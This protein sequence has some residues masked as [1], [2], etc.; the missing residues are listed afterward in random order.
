MFDTEFQIVNLI[1]GIDFKTEF[2][3]SALSK[4]LPITDIGV[5]NVSSISYYGRDDIIVRISSKNN[6]RGLIKTSAGKVKE[7]TM[8]NIIDIDYQTEGKNIHFKVSKTNIHITGL[9]SYKMFENATENFIKYLIETE[10]K[11]KK[12]MGCNTDLLIDCI[13]ESTE[14]KYSYSDEEFIKNLFDICETRGVDVNNAELLI[15]Y[16]EGKLD[17]DTLKNKLMKV[18]DVTP[19]PSGNYLYNEIPQ[20]E[21]IGIYNGLY[22]FALDVKHI[23]LSNLSMI[24]TDDYNKNA[25][26]IQNQSKEISIDEEISF[27]DIE[28]MRYGSL[29]TSSDKR[30][31]RCCDIPLVYKLTNNKKGEKFHKLTINQTGRINIKSPCTIDIVKRVADEYN[32]II[33]DIYNKKEIEDEGF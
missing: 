30:Y 3:I 11:I 5:K 25:C 21:N 22:T 32:D 19:Y 14:G 24:L 7:T 6:N 31:F 18:I 29:L 23:V 4:L 17:R 2:N 15:S 9:K 13:I 27:E 1:I 33:N 16:V 12:L 8:T 20:P 26:Y 10:E 28:E